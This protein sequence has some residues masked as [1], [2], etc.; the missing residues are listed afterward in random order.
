LQEL[1]QRRPWFGLGVVLG[2]GALAARARRAD[3]GRRRVALDA[4]N[5][6]DRGGRRAASGRAASNRSDHGRDD[7]HVVGELYRRWMEGVVEVTRRWNERVR[8]H[9]GERCRD[10]AGVE[11]QLAS[12]FERQQRASDLLACA[13]DTHASRV[14]VGIE[15]RSKAATPE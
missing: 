4:R 14:T 15:R 8:D 1:L 10:A 7:R 6:V 13:A 3:G 2:A 11:A 5:V 9:V 12:G